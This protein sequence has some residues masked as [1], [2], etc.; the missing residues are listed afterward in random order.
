MEKRFRKT[1]L[2]ERPTNKQTEK[3]RKEKPKLQTSKRTFPAS[4]K[5]STLSSTRGML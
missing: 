4:C 3:E 5:T 2:T 1:D